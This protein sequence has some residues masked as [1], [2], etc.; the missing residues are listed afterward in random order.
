MKKMEQEIRMSETRLA[1]ALEH[2]FNMGF[3]VTDA[4]DLARLVYENLKGVD[5]DE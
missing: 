1:N 2:Y 4:Y 5:E 3:T